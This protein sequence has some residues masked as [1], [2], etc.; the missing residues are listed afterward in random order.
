VLRTVGYATSDSTLIGNLKRFSV[1]LAGCFIRCAPKENILANGNRH[2]LR[3][4]A[5]KEPFAP[6]GADEGIRAVSIID[7]ARSLL[8]ARRNAVG[9]PLNE[10]PE[11]RHRNYES[12][13]RP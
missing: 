11:N 9:C 13:G 10:R 4:G 12:D 2:R 1:S 6:H 7:P 8:E 5:S 3:R